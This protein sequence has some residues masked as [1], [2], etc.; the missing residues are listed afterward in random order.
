MELIDAIL[1]NC[2]DALLG[3][4]GGLVVYLYHFSTHREKNHTVEFD[5][6]IFI[7][8]GVVGGF[9]AFTLG[10]LIPHSLEYRDGIIGLIGVTAFGFMAVVES[11]FVNEFLKKFAKK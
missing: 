5:V 3:C 10:G 8:N 7:I 11:K 2:R 6:V 4:S 9:M 1:K